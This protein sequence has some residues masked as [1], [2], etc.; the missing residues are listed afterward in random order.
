MF[1]LFWCCDVCVSN[2]LVLVSTVGTGTKS[3][4]I[5][6]VLGMKRLEFNLY[7]G[8]IRLVQVFANRYLFSD[9]CF[10]FRSI[11]RLENLGIFQK[12]V[13]VVCCTF[14]WIGSLRIWGVGYVWGTKGIRVPKALRGCTQLGGIRLEIALA[15]R[16]FISFISVF[17]Q[18]VVLSKGNQTWSLWKSYGL[19]GKW[20]LVG[21]E[22]FGV[23][24]FIDI[25][26][27]LAVRKGWRDGVLGTLWNYGIWY[28]IL[29]VDIVKAVWWLDR[30]LKCSNQNLVFGI[31]DRFGKWL[32]HFLCVW[33]E[34]RLGRG[35]F[36]RRWIRIKGR[37]MFIHTGFLWRIVCAGKNSVGDKLLESWTWI[38]GMLKV[39]YVCM[40]E[41]KEWQEAGMETDIYW[42]N[43]SCVFNCLIWCMIVLD[44]CVWYAYSLDLSF[45]INRARDQVLKRFFVRSLVSRIDVNTF[46]Y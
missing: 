34:A 43:T 36:A 2:L 25:G 18:F 3:A 35:N 23:K 21:L 29:N 30:L 22:R 13:C 32:V 11:Q 16:T 39:L 19:K 10:I 27:L 9:F 42:L 24:D 44:I 5:D 28:R 40:K 37:I 46:Y 45:C 15:A 6:W 17:C 14:S 20:K 7:L 41:A 1:Y 8:A 26:E 12:P 4:V 31:G 38:M 33:L